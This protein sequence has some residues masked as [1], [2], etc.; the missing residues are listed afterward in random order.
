MKNTDR[1]TYRPI[2]NSDISTEIEQENTRQ[3]GFFA[4]QMMY[5]SQKR[6]DLRRSFADKRVA[7][8]KTIS[9]QLKDSDL[10]QRA[11]EYELCD[12]MIQKDN[13]C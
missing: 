10:L 2:Q 7:C 13:L 5:D 3:L 1:Y 12:E 6:A 9:E 8:P 11:M 4:L